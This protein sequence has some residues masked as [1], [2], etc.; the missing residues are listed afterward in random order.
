MNILKLII[1]KLKNMYILLT[2]IISVSK[3]VTKNIFTEIDALEFFDILN[4]KLTLTKR[5]S[6]SPSGYFIK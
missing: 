6:I 5:C 3:N 1:I 4:T 2:L